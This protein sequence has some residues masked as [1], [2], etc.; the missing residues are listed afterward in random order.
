PA[1][2][3]VEAEVVLLAVLGNPPAFVVV[4][5]VMTGRQVVDPRGRG[6]VGRV[7]GMRGIV[8]D[9]RRGCPVQGQRQNL[10]IPALIPGV[11]R[12][13]GGRVLGACPVGALDVI[14]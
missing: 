4:R 11:L 12:R 5:A 8:V 14:V 10:P 7:K 3:L 2:K 9:D 13:A 1:R 6:V